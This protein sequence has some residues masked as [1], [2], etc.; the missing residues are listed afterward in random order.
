MK[1]EKLEKELKD[2]LEDLLK[3][4]ENSSFLFENIQSKYRLSAR[5]LFRYLVLRTYDLRKI[6]DNLSELGI[7]S[8]RTA[9]GYVLDNILNTLKLVK[10]LQ[11][12][13]WKPDESPETIGF[14][15]SKKLLRKHANKLFGTNDKKHNSHIMVT[16]PSE[17]A[18][19]L[20]LIRNLTREGM[21][22]AR[23]NLSHDDIPT[24][25]KMIQNIKLVAKEMDVPLQ[26]YMDLAGPKIRIGEIWVPKNK[27]VG[28]FRNFIR[29]KAD[30]HLWL[31]KEQTT[32]KKAVWDTEGRIISWA[33][34][35]VSLPQIIDDIKVGDPI[36][37]DDGK[38]EA[39]VI[40][41]QDDRVELLIIHAH[42]SK[43]GAEKGIN[44]PHTWLNLPSLTERDIELLPFVNQYADIVGYSFVRYEEDVE[45]LYNE[46][47]P[48]DNK[49]L[50][51]VF[52]IETREAFESL[53]LIL[54]K[55]MRRGK[56]GVMIARGDLAVE[57]GY[58]RISEVQNEI[59]W[60][61]EAAHVPVIW[62][63]Q[64]LENLAK[65]G[66]AT[67]AEVSDV[68][69]S[70]QAECVMLNKGPHIVQ[71][72]RTLNNI[73]EKMDAHT[74]KK[75]SKMRPL[76]VAKLNLDKI[77]KMEKNRNSKALQKEAVH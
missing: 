46:L 65:K 25:E 63:T 72:V 32:G 6:Q 24:W 45:K 61:C 56:I 59:L 1:L 41:K 27:K 22:V 51:V 50:G 73:L 60:L 26:I 64:V 9:E 17:A 52:K 2:V 34:V 44:L 3:K 47:E 62:A 19:N 68:S 70:V 21:E 39:R 7:S 8:L 58:E 12:K 40:S 29:V 14:S 30:D 76:M 18:E 15:K 71:A 5:N 74:S 57:I 16:M 36:F 48:F 69:V 20:E 28:E 10:L 54:L 43:L 67:R 33:E 35:S 49:D 31:T 53:P 55:A 75:K 42:K 37:F 4:E 66:I 38:I 23:I 11:G 77:K 13:K